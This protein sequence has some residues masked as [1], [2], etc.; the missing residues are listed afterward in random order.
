VPSIEELIQK[1]KALV[2]AAK[3]PATVKAYR[4]DWRDF[5]FWCR[6]SHFNHQNAPGGRFYLN[7]PATTRPFVVGETLNGIRRTKNG[8][9]VIRKVVEA[10]YPNQLTWQRSEEYGESDLPNGAFSIFV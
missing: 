2:A 4:I 3:A 6:P 5:E 8:T 7:S 1:A 9:A 10:L